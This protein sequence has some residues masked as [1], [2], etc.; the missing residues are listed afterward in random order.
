MG[1]F[2]LISLGG[3]PAWTLWRWQRANCVSTDLIVGRDSFLSEVFATV[4][5]SPVHVE[6]PT[7]LI[8]FVELGKGHMRPW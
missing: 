7:R 3:T 4:F 8:R 1:I 5:L 6:V 2:R